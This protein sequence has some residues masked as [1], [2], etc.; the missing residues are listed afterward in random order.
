M[1]ARST[2]IAK[3]AQATVL[4]SIIT[5]PANDVW[6]DGALDAKAVM[7]KMG[8]DERAGFIS[9]IVEGLAYARYL[10]DGK[11]AEGMKCIQNWYFKGETS[12]LSIIEAFDKFP[13]YAPANIIAALARKQCG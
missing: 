9:G 11:N 13:D 3:L 1:S 12:Q 4:A 8:S 7:T 5:I 6:A 2:G 10:A